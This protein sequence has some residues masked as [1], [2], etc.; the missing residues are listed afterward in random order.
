MERRAWRRDGTPPQRAG[1]SLLERLSASL[2]SPSVEPIASASTATARLENL[3][4]SCVRRESRPD[5][6]QSGNL[7]HQRARNRHAP[8][9]EPAAGCVAVQFTQSIAKL[10]RVIPADLFHWKL[11]LWNNLWQQRKITGIHIHHGF[12]LPLSHLVHR[13]QKCLHD[14]HT[15][16]SLVW[17]P[18]S[19]LS[20]P[21]RNS[22]TS[23]TT[24]SIPLDLLL[25]KA[26]ST[27][28]INS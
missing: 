3:R 12:V 19:A 21:I 9:A 20:E 27:V 6:W 2:L 1:R 25:L 18:V 13:E 11:C 23:M 14:L 17:L 26:S 28:D 10:D 22:P 7:P 16:L 8:L 5:D 15:M 24:N 4:G